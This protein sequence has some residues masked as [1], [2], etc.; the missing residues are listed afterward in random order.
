MIVDGWRRAPSPLLRYILRKT[1]LKRGCHVCFSLL[2]KTKEESSRKA[3]GA[4]FFDSGELLP[5][6]TIKTGAVKIF[7]LPDSDLLSFSRYQV[8]SLLL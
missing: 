4:L 6:S 1:N 3:E 2:S 7:G 5:E 8:S